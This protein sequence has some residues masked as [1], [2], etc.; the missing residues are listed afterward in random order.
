[1][2]APGWTGFF[3]LFSVVIFMVHLDDLFQLH[4]KCQTPSLLSG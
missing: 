4:T 2:N 1:M 3:T